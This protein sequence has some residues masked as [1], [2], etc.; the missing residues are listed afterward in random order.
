MSFGSGLSFPVVYDHL[1]RLNQSARSPI[2]VASVGN[3]SDTLHGTNNIL[4][5][6]A[7]RGLINVGALSEDTTH[8]VWT[9]SRTGKP[10]KPT[11]GELARRTVDCYAPGEFIWGCVPTDLDRQNGVRWCH[12]TSFAAPMVSA[13]FGLRLSKGNA[14]DLPPMTPPAITR[15]LQRS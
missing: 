15:E 9:G 5:P 4:Y 14:A 10:K 8:K 7:Y 13:A 3:K 12:G 1:T 2:V 11:D 6:A